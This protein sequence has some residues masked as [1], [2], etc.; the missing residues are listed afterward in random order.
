MMLMLMLMVVVLRLKMYVD[1]SV[2]AY[3]IPVFFVYRPFTLNAKGV[4]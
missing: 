3:I 4:W 1:V 2:V